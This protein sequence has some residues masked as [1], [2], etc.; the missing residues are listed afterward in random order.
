MP[1][2][3][4]PSL[5]LDRDFADVTPKHLLSRQSTEEVKFNRTMLATKMRKANVNKKFLANRATTTTP[6][7]R[8]RI[9]GIENT[10]AAFKTS[11]EQARHR[12][13]NTARALEENQPLGRSHPELAEQE[14]LNLNRRHKS[15]ISRNV[16]WGS[17]ADAFREP[18]VTMEAMSGRGRGAE[19]PPPH[20]RSLSERAKASPKASRDAAREVRLAD[21]RKNVNAWAAQERT[22]I[23]SGTKKVPADRGDLGVLKNEDTKPTSRRADPGRLRAAAVRR[24]MG[25]HAPELPEVDLHTTDRA[26]RDW[27]KI[28]AIKPGDLPD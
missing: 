8:D 14:G 1:K 6:D 3:S 10:R 2:K 11:T 19:L 9:Q 12:V 17:T 18:D 21:M 13:R 5:N 22:D 4:L 16:A 27:N 25:G 24:G 7:E 20:P 15:L 23:E 28:K 26:N